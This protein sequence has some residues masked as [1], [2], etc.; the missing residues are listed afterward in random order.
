ML[1]NGV[2][3]VLSHLGLECRR[4]RHPTRPDRSVARGAPYGVADFYPGAGR[5]AFLAALLVGTAISTRMTAQMIPCLKKLLLK[6]I[7][8]RN[9][10]HLKY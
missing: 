6:L 5:L 2:L 8:S 7:H 3:S 10:L 9:Y 4:T 1:P